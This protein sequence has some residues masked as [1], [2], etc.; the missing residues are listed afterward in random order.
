[1]LGLAALFTIFGVQ[2]GLPL[3]LSALFGGLGGAA[4]LLFHEFGHV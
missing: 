4:S 1:V 2:V 3:V